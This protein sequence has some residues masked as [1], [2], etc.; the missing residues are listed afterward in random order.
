MIPIDKMRQTKSYLQTILTNNGYYEITSTLMAQLS[1]SDVSALFAAIKASPS[2]SVCE[3]FLHPLRDMDLTMR[4]FEPWLRDRCQIMIIGPDSRLLVQRIVDPDGYYGKSDWN[5]GQLVVWVVAIPLYFQ[6]Y[7]ERA[8]TLRC[9]W[10]DWR[11]P[12]QECEEAF[13]EY[14]RVF[15][16]H[17]FRQYPYNFADLYL[18]RE[19]NQGT[20]D[21]NI[22]QGDHMKTKVLDPLS[23]SGCGEEFVL[24]IDFEGLHFFLPWDMGDIKLGR[25]RWKATDGIPYINAANPFHVQV[26]ALDTFMR[27]GDTKRRISGGNLVFYCNAPERTTDST[28]SIAINHAFSE[29]S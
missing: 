27:S 14:L 20:S 1:A 7:A 5:A 28:V 24:G 6:D 16:Q 18:S 19:E 25:R 17:I 10:E 26:G 13:R 21:V 3:R 9:I 12:D 15:D 8:S 29:C 2:T 4:K 22:I 11:T 23:R